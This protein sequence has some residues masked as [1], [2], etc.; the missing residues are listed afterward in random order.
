MSQLVEI[1]PLTTVSIT[2]PWGNVYYKQPPESVPDLAG[3]SEALVQV[4]ITEVSLWNGAIAIGVD[5]AV[6]N[7]DPH[8]YYIGNIVSLTSPPASYPYY[9]QQYLAPPSGFARYLRL[10]ITLRGTVT[11]KLGLT[12]I[13]KP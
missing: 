5:T 4:V 8:Y 10:R 7:F 2:S 1:L 3:Y 11:L 13:V 6:I 12:A 9:A